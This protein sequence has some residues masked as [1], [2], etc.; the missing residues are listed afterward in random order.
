MHVQTTVLK[1][2]YISGVLAVALLAPKVTKILPSFDGG[3]KGRTELY[4]RISDA[5]YRLKQRGLIQESDGC[6][7]L[8]DNGRES[9]ERLLMQEYQIPER[10]RW[11]GKWRM[12]IFDI[13]EGRR[14][15]RTQLRQLLQSAGFVRLQ[16]SVWIH[17]YP[18]DEFVA[19]VRAHLSSGVGEL[20]H[21][22]VEALESDKPLREHFNLPI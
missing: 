11:D 17:P 21:V 10:I 22:V 5:R 9:I 4:K 8:T 16:D 1:T 3:K 12:L 14:R 2:L 13:H 7:K 20:R 6:I 18:C 15:V 19:L